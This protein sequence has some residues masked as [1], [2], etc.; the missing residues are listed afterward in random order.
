[1]TGDSAVGR[2]TL[3]LLSASV[4]W[5]WGASAGSAGIGS[6]DSG[7]DTTAGTGVSVSRLG[8]PGP[9]RPVVFARSDYVW[10]YASGPYHGDVDV[11]GPG[12]VAG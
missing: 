8:L 12:V 1:M 9:E 7:P 5:A 3:V 2:F 6:S 11:A 10:P 4:L